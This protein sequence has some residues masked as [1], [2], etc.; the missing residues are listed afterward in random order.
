M[1]LW[2]FPD[3]RIKRGRALSY[4]HQTGLPWL[5]PVLCFAA[6]LALVLWAAG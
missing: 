5:R 3:P 4:W 2:L 1:I 6:A